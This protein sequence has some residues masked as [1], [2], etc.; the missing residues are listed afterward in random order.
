VTRQELGRWVEGLRKA[1]AARHGRK[2]ILAIEGF[3]PDAG[4]DTSS[5]ERLT[6]FVRRTPDP[7]LQLTRL[8]VLERIR[9]GS[10]SGTAFFDPSVMNVDELLASPPKPALHERIADQNLETVL[11]LG[12][13][14]IERRYRD[15]LRDRD[16]SY[17]GIDP[18]I[19]RRADA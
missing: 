16:D 7:T 3:H 10:P 2:P 1:H 6:P 5:A 17:A 12:V 18:T 15:I 11:S 19:I 8:A 13:P 9:R 4:A 14:E